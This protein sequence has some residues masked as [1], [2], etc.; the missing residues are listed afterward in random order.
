MRKR[1]ATTETEVIPS[2]STVSQWQDLGSLSSRKIEDLAII[3]CSMLVVRVSADVVGQGSL[4]GQRE[5]AHV[6]QGFH[7]RA[8]GCSDSL[9]M[10][11]SSRVLVTAILLV[12]YQGSALSLEAE[13]G[14]CQVGHECFKLLAH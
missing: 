12:W 6:R 2:H 9:S 11:Q 4:S 5:S 13:K 7:D 8:K 10:R 14:S 3:H 1:Q